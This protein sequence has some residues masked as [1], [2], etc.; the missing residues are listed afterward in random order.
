MIVFAIASY[1][2]FTVQPCDLW[3][4]SWWSCARARG[5]VACAFFAG[6]LPAPFTQQFRFRIRCSVDGLR[7]GITVRNYVQTDVLICTQTVPAAGA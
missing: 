4:V 3:Y 6:D 7:P 1:R 5:N 2:R